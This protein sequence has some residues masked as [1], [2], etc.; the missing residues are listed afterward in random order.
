MTNIQVTVVY[1][2][3]SHNGNTESL[4]SKIDKIMNPSYPQCVIGDFNFSPDKKNHFTK[5][6]ERRKLQQIVQE[7][8]QEA[9]R[10]LD[11]CYVSKDLCGKVQLKCVFKYFSDHA[12]LQIKFQL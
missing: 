3:I 2:N 11:H 1:N 10:I 9:G 5:F 7:P 4:T 6:M 8:T 12:A